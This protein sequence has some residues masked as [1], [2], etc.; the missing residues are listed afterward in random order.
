MKKLFVLACVKKLANPDEFEV[1][2]L[3]SDKEK[4]F[5]KIAEC[6]PAIQAMAQNYSCNVFDVLDESRTPE[7]S[8]YFDCDTSMAI[9]APKE[10]PIDWPER[11]LVIDYFTCDM[12]FDWP[13]FHVVNHFACRLTEYGHNSYGKVFMK[14]GRKAKVEIPFSVEM[15]AIDDVLEDYLGA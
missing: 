12:D 3:Y 11:K 8:R 2:M 1:Q 9:D 15:Q 7:Y 10:L 4:N 5:R 13:A 14:C 6:S